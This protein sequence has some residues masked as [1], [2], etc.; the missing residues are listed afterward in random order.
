MAQ[1]TTTSCEKR[2]TI[3]KSGC[4]RGIVG[5]SPVK[6]R[7][8]IRRTGVRVCRS[9][10][11]RPIRLLMLNRSVLLTHTT[12]FCPA[13]GPWPRTSTPR[14]RPSHILRVRL[15]HPVRAG[16]DFQTNQR[17]I[18]V[19]S[20]VR[21]D[22][23]QTSCPFHRSERRGAAHKDQEHRVVLEIARLNKVSERTVR[24]A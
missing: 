24:R 8:A 22:R 6:Q 14:R 23:G 21:P 3:G 15:H 12:I 9:T 19:S 17:R 11:K 2:G 1:V 20:Q 13:S 7:S 18:C 10:G 5:M 4:G 16:P